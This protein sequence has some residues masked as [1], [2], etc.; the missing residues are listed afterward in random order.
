MNVEEEADA[1]VVQKL[2]RIVYGGK[3]RLDSF[4][5]L[6]RLYC[7][8]DKWQRECVLSATTSQIKVTCKGLG[9][10]PGAPRP[11]RRAH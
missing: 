3:A 1:S 4:D 5:K 7:L 9:P 8:A 11:G 6:V 10:G 2:I